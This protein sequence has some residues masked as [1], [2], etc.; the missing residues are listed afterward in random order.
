[1]ILSLGAPSQIPGMEQFFRLMLDIGWT[2]AQAPVAVPMKTA[3]EPVATLNITAAGIQLRTHTEVNGGILLDLDDGA[4]QV[5][6]GW[7][8]ATERS[9]HCCTIIP[10]TPGLGMHR[11]YALGT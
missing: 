5:P 2:L 1:L 3:Q 7:W 4:S 9:G 8:E 11:E 10:P 6:A